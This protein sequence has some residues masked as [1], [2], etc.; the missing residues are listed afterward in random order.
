[1]PQVT[2]KIEKQDPPSSSEYLELFHGIG[3][4]LEMNITGGIDFGMPITV[5]HVSGFIQATSS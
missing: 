5:F 2:F 3:N 4:T 1:M